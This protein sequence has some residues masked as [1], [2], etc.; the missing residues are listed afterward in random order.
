MFITPL[1]KRGY[2]FGSAGLSVPL[3]VGDISQK[4]MNELQGN[5]ME[6]WV[7]QGRAGLIMVAI[8]VFIDE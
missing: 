5:F 6:S 7:L 1:A 2:V 3:L 8:W 4:N